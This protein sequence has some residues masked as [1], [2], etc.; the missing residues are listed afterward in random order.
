MKGFSLQKKRPLFRLSKEHATFARTF[1]AQKKKRRGKSNWHCPAHVHIHTH[2]H[3][4]IHVPRRTQNVSHFKK[5]KLDGQKK[6]KKKET[7]QVEYFFN[8]RAPN[9]NGAACSRRFCG[10]T[11]GKKETGRHISTRRNTAVQDTFFVTHT[12]R[13]PAYSLYKK[14]IIVKNEKNLQKLFCYLVT[15]SKRVLKTA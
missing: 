5:K 9:P 8:T 14:K 3:T 4:F 13:P 10:G 6:K 11:R 2:M 1:H 15:N 7:K 12:K